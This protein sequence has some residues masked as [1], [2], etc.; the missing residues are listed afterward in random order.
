MPRNKLSDLNDHLF[1]ALERLN[2]E[3]LTDEDLE[4]EIK[5]AKAISD[6]AKPI[7]NNADVVLKAQKHMDEWGYGETKRIMPEMLTVGKAKNGD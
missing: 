3:D 5:R 4:K 6:I 1:M 2:D 7:I